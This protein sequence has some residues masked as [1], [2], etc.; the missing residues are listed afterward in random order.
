MRALVGTYT[1]GKSEGIYQFEYI[2]GKIQSSTLFCQV[3]SPKYIAKVD[4]YFV[5]LIEQKDQSGLCLIDSQ[6]SI[7][8]TVLYE[9]IP[10][11]YVG[12][13]NQEVFTANYHEGTISK[14]IFKD[15][16]LTFVKQVKI[17]DKAG[18]HQVLFV[19]QEVWLFALKQDKAYVFDHDLNLL[20]TIDFEKG[21]GCR[22]GVVSDDQKWIYVIGELS[23]HLY[24]ID[25]DHHQ[26][27]NS[28]PVLKDGKDFVEGGGAIRKL[29]DYVYVSTR[30]EDVISVIQVDRSHME[31]VDVKSTK[32]KHPRDFV[33][34]DHH[35][36]VANKDTDDIYCMEINE[37][38]TIGQVT[39]KV[40]VSEPVSIL[41]EE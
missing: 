8:D 40:E 16:H 9:K 15:H 28:I 29:D 11:C 32:G 10:S 26:V 38:H 31:L 35:L 14:L 27:V 6:G 34:Y 21:A 18:C 41:M 2:Q 22:H 25:V 1:T 39:S 33:I 19:N 37:D 7:V 13:C 12:V 23:N 36:I 4:R 5:S 30:G 17:A 3:N 20:H 24:A